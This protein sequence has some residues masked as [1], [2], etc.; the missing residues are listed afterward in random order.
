M[1]TVTNRLIRAGVDRATGFFLNVSQYQTN[2]AN[3][4]Y[5]RLVSSCLAY[6]H[7]GGD[8][9]DCPDQHRPARRRGRGS[10]RTRPVAG[11][12]E[13]L[14]HR[15]QPQRPGS[16]D[17]AARQALRPQD[18]CNPPGR[19]LGTRP[20]TKTS[21]PLEDAL[22]W[23]KTR[24]VGRA[25]PA[26]HAGPGGPRTRGARPQ[27]GPVVPAAGAGV[28]A[29]RGPGGGGGPGGGEGSR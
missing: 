3:A 26:G 1:K 20:T 4:W 11:A 13:A 2:E 21:D 9:E 22:L 18:W 16:V 23:V 7:D 10:T 8:P 6:A 24:G 19:G 29:V 12:D 25:V 5:G 14:R 28:G 15:H 17:P 27:G